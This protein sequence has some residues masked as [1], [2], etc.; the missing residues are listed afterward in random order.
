MTSMNA[1]AH[2]SAT[3]KAVVSWGQRLPQWPWQCYVVTSYSLQS[4]ACGHCCRQTRRS[5]PR[6]RPRAH[7]CGASPTS[8]SL[9]GPCRRARCPALPLCMPVISIMG[10]RAA[11]V[12]HAHPAW[13]HFPCRLAQWLSEHSILQLCMYK[14]AMTGHAA[15]GLLFTRS[16][17][18]GVG[19]FCWGHAMF[20][21]MV[22]LR[23]CAAAC[24]GAGDVCVD[25]RAL[26]RLL[27][28]R[29]Q[30]RLQD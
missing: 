28:V 12:L 25:H 24:G 5:L 16:S 8:G 27:R 19:C 15:A 4:G 18:T 3:L 26:R 22:L 9:R 23:V 10:C 6:P 17:L 20:C 11:A 21:L 14:P 30:A 29:L 13:S 1:C 2:R 7:C